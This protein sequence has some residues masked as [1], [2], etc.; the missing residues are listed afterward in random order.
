MVRRQTVGSCRMS[1]WRQSVVS[2]KDFLIM[3]TYR[4]CDPSFVAWQLR[5]FPGQKS[6]GTT[7]SRCRGPRKTEMTGCSISFQ[8]HH[9]VRVPLLVDLSSMAGEHGHLSCLLCGLGMAVG[10]TQEEQELPA[11]VEVMEST[12]DC[13]ANQ[14]H[15]VV[16]HLTPT[17]RICK[18]STTASVRLSISVSAYRGSHI[19]LV[20]PKAW[21][22]KRLHMRV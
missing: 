22:T 3:R 12:G 8:Q 13:T 16:L 1:R 10:T 4:L 21:W 17:T 6:V 20:F 9:G 18:R 7:W 19:T 14:L 11:N 2:V 5:T 15:G